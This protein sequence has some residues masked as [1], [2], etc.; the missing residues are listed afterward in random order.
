M[1][2]PSRYGGPVAYHRCQANYSFSGALRP[3][4]K[5]IIC[6]VMLRGRHRGLPVAIDR[7]VMLP[8]EYHDED[9]A[10]EYEPPQDEFRR[11]ARSRSSTTTSRPEWRPNGDAAAEQP[12]AYMASGADHRDL[13]PSRGRDI[14]PRRPRKGSVRTVGPG[15]VRDVEKETERVV[16]DLVQRGGLMA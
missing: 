1:S 9:D 5:L 8:S 15:A 11:Y 10:D 16:D 12:S 3:L 14:V 7:A 2:T 4:S 13:S 6:A